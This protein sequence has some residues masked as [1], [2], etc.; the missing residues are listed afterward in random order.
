LRALLDFRQAKVVRHPLRNIVG[1]PLRTRET[2][3]HREYDGRDEQAHCV[4]PIGEV[5]EQ[6]TRPA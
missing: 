4:D 6:A 3:E 1:R 2:G 5:L